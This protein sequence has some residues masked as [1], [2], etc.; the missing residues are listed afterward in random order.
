MSYSENP[1]KR[2]NVVIFKPAQKD[3]VQKE[4]PPKINRIKQNT[5]IHN[6]CLAL[7][8]NSSYEMA[9]EITLQLSLANPACSIMYAPSLHIARFIL[10]RRKIDLIISSPILPDGPVQSLESVFSEINSHPDIIVVGD[11]NEDSVNLLLRSKYQFVS[12][13][14]I[15][16]KKDN[17]TQIE[18]ATKI[19]SM[20]EIVR[21]LGA[22]IRNDLNNPLQEIV[23]MAF[24]ARTGKSPM[25][26][27]QALDA[28]DK[29]AKNMS[30]VVNAIEQKI[31]AKIIGA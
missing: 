12:R 22:D 28:I 25:P 5:A 30:G 7:V 13:H 3:N 27:D 26:V 9:K 31:K 6:D 29:A 4:T 18:K 2:K 14:S 1:I 15:G 16:S 11:P 10:K 19:T 21:T 8:I 24:V 17:H 23:A 20:D